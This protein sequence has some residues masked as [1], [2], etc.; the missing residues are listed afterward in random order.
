VEGWADWQKPY[1]QGTF[2]LWPPDGV[3]EVVNALR[4]RYD[5]VSQAICETHITL[6]QPLLREPG[7][8]VWA[9]LRRVAAG[10]AQFE[11]TY[12]PLRSFLPYPCIWYEIQPAAQVLALRAALHR[13][14]LFNLDR[15]Y[16][17]GFIPHMTITAGQ[18]GPEVSEALL[19]ALKGQVTG[20]TFPVSE[21][22]YIV[23]D[24]GFHFAVRKRLP[25]GGAS[26]R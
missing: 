25:L 16:T 13:T 20:G 14:G 10:H 1:A 2:V 19:E 5:P 21:I 15:P 4:Q 22:A 17:E 26:G 18:S 8:D 23:P 11:I 6:T 3:R 7:A 24:A 9:E 12:G